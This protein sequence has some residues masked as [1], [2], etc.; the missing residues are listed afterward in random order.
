MKAHAAH[1]YG[2][3]NIDPHMS[4][5][6]DVAKEGGVATRTTGENSGLLLVGGAQF[7]WQPSESRHGSGA[8]LWGRMPRLRGKR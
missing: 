6:Y 7:S 4:R 8:F 3:P 2:A 1:K 5:A